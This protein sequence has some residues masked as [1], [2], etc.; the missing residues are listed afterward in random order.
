MQMQ[1]RARTLAAIVSAR[2][3]ELGLS[4]QELASAVGVG[5]ECIWRI[6]NDR[7][8]PRMVTRRALAAAL[9]LPVSDLTTEV[10][11]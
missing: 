9:D 2:R 4:R 8:A 6:E 10:A 1:V 11:A 3:I 5:Y 7:V